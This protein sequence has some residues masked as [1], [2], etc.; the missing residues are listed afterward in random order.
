[1]KKIITIISFVLSIVILIFYSSGMVDKK[2]MI[3]S[4]TSENKTPYNDKDIEELTLIR[5][6]AQQRLIELQKQEK[7]L[8]KLKEK[9]LANNN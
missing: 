6:S 1:M 9:I 2:D 3:N 8:L 5:E 4:I 7:E